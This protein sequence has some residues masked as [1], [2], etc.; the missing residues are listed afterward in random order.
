MLKNLTLL[1]LVFAVFSACKKDVPSSS[2]DSNT[3]I[4]GETIPE[5]KIGGYPVS[6]FI[7]NDSQTSLSVY[8]TYSSSLSI[9]EPVKTKIKADTFFYLKGSSSLSLL[10]VYYNIPGTS[11]YYE[12]TSI[13]SGSF[14]I[15]VYLRYGQGDYTIKLY[16]PNNGLLYQAVSFTVIN[17]STRDFRYLLPSPSIQAFHPSIIAKAKEITNG[18]A[19]DYH[20][21]KAI[22]DWIVKYLQYDFDSLVT[23]KPQDALT[24]LGNGLAVC[25]GYANL[26][27]AFL[28]AAGIQTKYIQGTACNSSND[29]GLHAWNETYWDSAWHIVDSTWDDPIMNGHSSYPDGSN[30]RYIYFDISRPVFEQNHNTYSTIE[31]RSGTGLKKYAPMPVVE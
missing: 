12:Y 5:E 26:Y 10:Y 15:P 28:R 22:H 8:S 6:G 19:G 17:T 29:C 27:A 21:A 3:V 23:R 16:V 4:N 7:A 25:E 9:T 2:G 1:F 20:K 24:V 30:L 18:I 14:S 11:N 13:P 31:S